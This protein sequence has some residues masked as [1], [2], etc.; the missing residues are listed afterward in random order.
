M[1]TVTS[2]V[3][4]LANAAAVNVSRCKDYFRCIL[5]ALQ[6]NRA[7]EAR[8]VIIRYA[9]LLAEGTKPA[10]VQSFIAAD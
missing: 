5:R 4:G 10:D 3:T 2:D 1:A 9:H 6:E 8:R 7:R